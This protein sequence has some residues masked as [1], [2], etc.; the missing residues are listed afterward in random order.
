MF[1]CPMFLGCF[2][3]YFLHFEGLGFCFLSFCCVSVSILS[4]SLFATADS[5]SLPLDEL[6]DDLALELEQE[7][8]A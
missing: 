7:L 5:S 3:A 1:A 2:V 8:D 6:L 4:S